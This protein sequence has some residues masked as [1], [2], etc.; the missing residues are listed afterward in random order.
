[1]RPQFPLV[2]L[3]F[4]GLA[5]NMA[6]QLT[7]PQILRYFLDAALD[8]S[9]NAPSM[10]EITTAA[11]AFLLIALIIQLVSVGTTYLG[12]I[13]AWGSTNALREDLAAHSIGLDMSFHNAHTPGEFIQR[14][15]GD[16]EILGGFFSVFL[17]TILGNLILLFGTLAILYSENLTVGVVVT[18]S[19][20]VILTIMFTIR[21]LAVPSNIELSESHSSFYGF[22]EE[23]LSGREDI[24]ALGAT[25][26]VFER[27]SRFVKLVYTKT[28]K[29]TY[30]LNAIVWLIS[31]SFSLNQ[32]VALA[33]GAYL[34]FNGEVTLG[35]VFMI[36]QYIQ[37]SQTPLNSITNQVQELQ[38]FR[39]SV[40]RVEEIFNTESKLKFGRVALPDGALSVE[41]KNVSFNYHQDN[42]VLEDISFQLKSGKALG[43]LGETGS[44]K[45]TIARL[46]FRLYDPDKGKILLSLRPLN[47]YTV[48]SLRSR[49]GMITQ[50][51][52]MLSASVR[53]NVT[54]FD[55]SIPDSR[56][57]AAM[58]LLGLSR[59]IESLPYALDTKL[60]TKDTSISAGQAQLLAFSRVF[61]LQPGLIILDEAS[62]R[63][64]P[65][66]EQLMEKAIGLMLSQQTTSIVIA[67]RLQTIKRVDNIIIL[68][69]GRIVESGSRVELEKNPNSKLSKMLGLA[70]NEVL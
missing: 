36:I 17:I 18:F 33:L 29:S 35:T 34:Y 26:Y 42:H 47:E 40:E 66:T 30:V 45:T 8:S 52:Q 43:I 21:K 23:H 64:D 50:E 10:N 3:L 12:S 24:R 16:V 60:S 65:M 4:C 15:D 67:H 62:S 13:I 2:A 20:V 27:F 55:S 59:W 48:E 6:L 63:L 32:A 70:T 28:L 19:S 46:L 54:L 56:V 44:G 41:F 51:I 31:F 7:N 68:Q 49:I 69:D 22:L 37:I 61:L 1:M 38:K 58:E 57:N 9:Q 39:A 25:D 53:D 11:I 14:I 5:V